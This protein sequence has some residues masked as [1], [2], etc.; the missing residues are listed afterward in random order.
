[1]KI[2]HTVS[3]RLNEAAGV[4]EGKV[5]VRRKPSLSRQAST[6]TASSAGFASGL[7]SDLVSGLLSLASDGGA[8]AVIFLGASTAGAAVGAAGGAGVSGFAA[9]AIFGA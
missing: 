7:A 3:P 2:S 9:S 8:A 1:S 4:A 6:L 5:K